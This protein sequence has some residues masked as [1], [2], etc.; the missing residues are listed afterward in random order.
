MKAQF[1]FAVFLSTV[2]TLS[3]ALPTL[4]KDIF[5]ETTDDGKTVPA[6]LHDEF[7][8]SDEILAVE[9]NVEFYQYVM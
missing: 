5:W 6:F 2:L 7:L 8:K 3:T 1:V 4:D 9:D